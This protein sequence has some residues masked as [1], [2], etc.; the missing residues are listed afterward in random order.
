M[1]VL[2]V[3]EVMPAC[4][5]P[6]DHAA[7]VFTLGRSPVMGRSWVVG[8]SW[9]MEWEL[10]SESWMAGIMGRSWGAQELDSG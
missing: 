1:V 3:L 6:P 9:M 7:R 5:L 2:E 10:D 8:R 4:P